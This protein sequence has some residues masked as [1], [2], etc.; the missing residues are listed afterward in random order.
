M[1]L[2]D[3][4]VTFRLNPRTAT[5]LRRG[6]I[7]LATFIVLGLA[8]VIGVL[9]SLDLGKIRDH[10][11]AS[12]QAETGAVLTVTSAKQFYWPRPRVVLNG[13]SLALPDGSA[14]L[15]AA[16]AVIQFDVLDLLDSRI[17]APNITLESPEIRVASG[18]LGRFY[19]SPRAVVG[20]ADAISGTFSKV[21]SLSS[22]RL[23]VQKGRLIFEGGLAPNGDFLVDPLEARLKFHARRGRVELFARRASEIRPVELTLSLPTRQR[24]ANGQPAAAFMHV[25]GFGSRATFDGQ[26]SRA[27]D[28][29]MRGGIE[30]SIQDALERALG[31]DSSTPRGREEAV[32]TVSATMT[33]G[34]RGGGLEALRI[35]RGA[36]ALSG[37]AALRENEGR[38]SASATLAGDLVD[39]TATHAAMERLKTDDGGWSGKAL[40]VN[41]APAVDLDLRLSTKQ[42]R[43]GRLTFENAALSVLTRPGRTEFSIADARF[44]TG[45]V[46]ARI[47]LTERGGAQEMRLQMSGETIDTAAFLDRALGLNRIGGI[48]SF[49]FH[50]ESRGTSITEMVAGLAGTGSITIRNGEF[51]GIDLNRLMARSG[52]GRGEVALLGALGGRSPFQQLLVNVAIRSGRIEPVGSQLD[53]ERVG[54]S[55]EGFIDLAQQQHQLTGVLRRRRDQPGLPSEFFAFRIDGPLFAPVLRPDAALLLNRS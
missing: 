55:L 18:Q 6:L 32:T 26:I 16:R 4:K 3:R 11:V 35:R 17:D 48:G 54:G 41:P 42:F 5:L 23:V 15:L 27:P 8:A 49:A 19:N 12:L 45:S 24:L 33:L 20:I 31:L 37:I 47:A 10:V 53:H 38:W 21:K 22:I 28:F 2:L 46:K 52:P 25:S 1:S 51:S 14:S 29:E 44:G 50:A 39:G 7:G 36:G 40:D 9:A 30:A 43:L 13:V 34:P